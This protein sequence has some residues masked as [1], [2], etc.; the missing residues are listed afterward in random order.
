MAGFTWNDAG[1]N[2][3]EATSSSPLWPI[4]KGT[5]MV[6]GNEQVRFLSAAPQRPRSERE[7]TPASEAGIA[8]SIP[9][10][11]TTSPW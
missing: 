1:S 3:V 4:G 6:G 5:R 9:A 10:E 2:P 11:G 7:I 8:G